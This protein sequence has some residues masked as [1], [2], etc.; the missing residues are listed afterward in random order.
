M[1]IKKIWYPGIFPGHDTKMRQTPTVG[2]EMTVKAQMAMALTKK[3]LV[4]AAK[5]WMLMVRM[6]TPLGKPMSPAV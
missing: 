3:V 1:E 6:K 4:V 2:S 5:L